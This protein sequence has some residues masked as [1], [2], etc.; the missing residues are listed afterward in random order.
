MGTTTNYAFRYPAASDAA[1]GPTQ[2]QNLATDLDTRRFTDR[3]TAAWLRGAGGQ[4][5]TTAGTYYMVAF[6]NEDL[7]SGPGGHDNVTNNS[8]YTVAATRGGVYFVQGGWGSTPPAQCSLTAALYKNGVVL[9]GTGSRSVSGG[10]ALLTVNTK[11]WIGTLVAGDYIELAA[12][13]DVNATVI[14]SSSPYVPSLTI[15]RLMD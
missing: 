1:D 8:R 13:S 2:M 5:L 4:T 12:M 3:Q 7:D 15:Y 9:N 11:P 14:T 10:S 6:A